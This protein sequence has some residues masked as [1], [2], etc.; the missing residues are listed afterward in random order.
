MVNNRHPS[1]TERR[2]NYSLVDVWPLVFVR[3]QIHNLLTTGRTFYSLA[4]QQPQSS[5][6]CNIESLSYFT[7]CLVIHFYTFHLQTYLSNDCMIMS[8][9]WRRWQE[10]MNCHIEHKKRSYTEI[11]SC[12]IFGILVS[13]MVII[14][15]VGFIWSVLPKKMTCAHEDNKLHIAW[16][17][18][19][20]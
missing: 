3:I 14:V 7:Q 12:S 9:L 5:V 16:R 8:K 10:M 11:S 17:I 15:T 1:I 2:A 18:F 13:W 4:I 19:F 20:L 6:F